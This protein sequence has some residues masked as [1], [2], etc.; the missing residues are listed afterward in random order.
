MS[1]NIQ[2]ISI[3]ARRL[4][5]FFGFLMFL[6]FVPFVRSRSCLN[7]IEPIDDEVPPLHDKQISSVGYC[8]FSISIICLI[9]FHF[10]IK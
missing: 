1:N 4:K 5:S 3:F 2:K 9:P 8:Y 7:L 10:Q 6:A